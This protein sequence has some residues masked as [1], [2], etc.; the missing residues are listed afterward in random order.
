MATHNDNYNNA[1]VGRLVEVASRPYGGETS[2]RMVVI[3][4][5]EPF[6]RTVVRR[7]IRN[8]QDA[9][10]LVDRV[11]CVYGPFIMNVPQEVTQ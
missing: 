6:V 8:H 10:L 2:L 3:E 11:V 4:T 5:E 1:V 9:E 7:F